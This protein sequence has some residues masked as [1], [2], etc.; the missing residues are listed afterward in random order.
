MTTKKKNNRTGTIIAAT[1]LLIAASFGV[2][3]IAESK[4]YQHMKLLY[5]NDTSPN[6]FLQK[7]GWS[8]NKG[9][10]GKRFGNLT[11]A[12]IEKKIT[13]AVKH[14]AIEIDATD[15][16][17][18]KI[19]ALVTAIAKDMK[20]L[21]STFKTSGKEIRTILLAPTID[22]AALEKIRV[23]RITDAEKASK[24][25]VN[26]LAEVAEILSLEQRKILNERIMQFKS[27]RRRWYRG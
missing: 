11:D 22:R 7:A 12:E 18:E 16:Q 4:P 6:P 3:A 2:Q 9:D 8:H 25:L 10:H 19:T 23:S 13:R 24:E 26:T 14:V 15:E 17:R 20:P 21:R 5:S 27:M 1:A